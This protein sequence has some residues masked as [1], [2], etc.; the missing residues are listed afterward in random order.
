MLKNVVGRNTKLVR[1]V[2]WCSAV[3]LSTWSA[4][5]RQCNIQFRLP[6]SSL[7]SIAIQLRPSCL[8]SFC[9]K[10]FCFF[11]GERKILVGLSN[12]TRAPIL[13]DC[14]ITAATATAR[15]GKVN[16]TAERDSLFYFPSKWI[17]FHVHKSDFKAMRWPVEKSLGHKT[18]SQRWRLHSR[19]SAWETR[20]NS[21]KFLV[22]LQFNF[23]FN[24]VFFVFIFAFTAFIASLC[25]LME[26]F[27]RRRKK[28]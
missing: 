25:R 16:C 11:F 14:S 23:R 26:L 17:K 22:F 4:F 6:R 13:K 19:F 8:S 20:N 27:K 10:F 5:E 3:L 2:S 28:I 12:A 24:F 21:F 15:C 7:N 1:V 9:E 18:C